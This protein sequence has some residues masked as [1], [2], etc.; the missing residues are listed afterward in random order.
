L[1]LEEV[2]IVMIVVPLKKI[3]KKDIAGLVQEGV[4]MNGELAREEQRSIKLDCVHVV[5][6]VLIIIRLI[7]L[8]VQRSR[9]YLGLMQILNQR[10]QCKER[11]KTA[12]RLIML[13]KAKVVLGVKARSLMESLY[14]VQN[15]MRYLVDGVKHAI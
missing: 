6:N 5:R 9:N 12:R 3:G 1:D 4:T 8:L 15:V 10:R 13:A 2:K 14:C 7:A 11:L